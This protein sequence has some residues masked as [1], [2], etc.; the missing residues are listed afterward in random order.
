[1]KSIESLKSQ[2]VISKGSKV[3]LPKYFTK[4]GLYMLATILKSKQA[5]KTTLQDAI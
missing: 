1:M 4:K 3:K 2:N 5:T